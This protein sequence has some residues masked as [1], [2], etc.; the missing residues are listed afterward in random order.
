[1]I[2]YINKGNVEVYDSNRFVNNYKSISTVNNFFKNENRMFLKNILGNILE[3]P[4]NFQNRV[5]VCEN[6]DIFDF[7]NQFDNALTDFYCNNYKKAIRQF[8]T[9]LNNFPHHLDAIY[10][11]A[12]SQAGLGEFKD[13]INTIDIAIDINPRDYRLWNEKGSF[14]S[15]LNFNAEAI[16]CFDKSIQIHSNSYNWSNKAVLYHKCGNLY[17]ALECYDWALFHDSDDIFSIIGEAKVYMQLGDIEKV[18]DCFF[19]ASQIDSNDLEYLLEYGKF[20]LY[21]REYKKAIK[22]FDK[23]LRYD[24]CLEFVWMFKSIAFNELK[25]YNE[26]NICVQKAIEIDS[27]ILLRFNELFDSID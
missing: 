8:N 5:G 16:D 22:L 10:Y 24:A 13:A 3:V 26:A 12:L 21:K 27:E 17:E 23:C 20:M 2:E 6:W 7:N 14:L 11:K 1:M 25:L 4:L 18:E 9:L 19:K 15:E